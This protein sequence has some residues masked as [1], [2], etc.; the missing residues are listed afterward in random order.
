MQRQVE[1]A[2]AVRLVGGRGVGGVAPRVA[3]AAARCRRAGLVARG[4]GQRQRAGQKR[5]EATGPNLADR[6]KPGTKRHLVVDAQGTPLGVTLSGANFHDSRMLAVTLDALPGARTDRRGRPRCRP[7]KVQADKGYD[8]RRCRQECRARSI[9][10]RIARRGVDSSE[11]LGRHRWIVER[12]LAWLARLRR[13]VV[14]HGRRVDLHLAF[15]VLGC[16]LIEAALQCGL[17]LCSGP[18][19]MPMYGIAAMGL[20]SGLPLLPRLEFVMVGPS[21]PASGVVRAVAEVLQHLATSGFQPTC[22][23]ACKIGSSAL[24]VLIVR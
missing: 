9:T 19:Y 1:L 22:R 21:P 6:G 4:A 2:T 17:G 7:T 14:R 10:P 20:E 23:S 13:L 3:G 5:G 16:A 8:H 11:R 15:T 12:T 24:S 18:R